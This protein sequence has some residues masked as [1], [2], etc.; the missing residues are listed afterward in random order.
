MKKILITGANSYIGQSVEN[1]L[2]KTPNYFFVETLDMLNPDWKQFD[3]SKFDTVFHVAGIA[4]FSKDP[5]KKDLYYNINTNLTEQ[6]AKQAKESGV[7][8]FIFMSSIIVYGD[9]TKVNRVITKDT[10]PNPSDFYGD[11]KWQ[12]EL[13][14]QAL[15][16][17]SFK[18]AIIRPPMIYGNGSKGNYS[19]L[20]K[21]A[22]IIPLVPD[23][24]NERSMLY[25][26]NLCEFV[27]QLISH[28]SNGVFFPQNKEY[29]S[30]TQLMLT[31]AKMHNKKQIKT[32]VFNP[33][34]N[35]M[36]FN[37]NF[38]KMFGNLIYDKALSKYNFQYHIF[39]F[40]ESIHKTEKVNDENC[41][42]KWI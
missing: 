41:N 22:Q 23:Y 28:D 7:S 42:Y 14:L 29:V 5:S 24:Y 1:W 40:D 8:Q 2:L 31:I 39:N 13:K 32:K 12:A 20:S 9:S 3:F 34:I 35:L 33:V 36:F 25:V 19:R 16:D 18:V 15:I 21:L 11:S 27:K 30:T 38:K 4:H 10:K 26:G 6:V 17:D 37:D